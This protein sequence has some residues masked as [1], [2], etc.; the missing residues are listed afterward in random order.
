M[1]DTVAYINSDPIN[2][3]NININDVLSKTANNRMTALFAN[4]F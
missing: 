1:N 3:D 4:R 2:L